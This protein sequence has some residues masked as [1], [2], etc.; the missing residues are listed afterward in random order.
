MFTIKFPDPGCCA[1]LHPKYLEYFN[2]ML[3]VYQIENQG[4]FAMVYHK[5]RQQL[6]AKLFSHV[7]TAGEMF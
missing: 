7:T 5:S 2:T 1:P 4:K 3:L 6:A